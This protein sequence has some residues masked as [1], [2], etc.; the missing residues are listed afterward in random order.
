MNNTANNDILILVDAQLD[1]F[2]Y[3]VDFDGSLDASGNTDDPKYV[4]SNIMNLITQF[5]GQKIIYSQDWHP[6]DHMSF[7]TVQAPDGLTGPYPVHCIQGSRG[8]EIHPAI[9][10]ALNNWQAQNKQ[11]RTLQ[12]VKKACG[13][14]PF[15]VNNRL[16]E[17][18]DHNSVLGNTANKCS[19]DITL[20]NSVDPDDFDGDMLAECIARHCIENKNANIYIAGFVTNICVLSTVLDVAGITQQQVDEIIAKLKYTDQNL[21]V[22]NATKHQRCKANVSINNIFVVANCCLASNYDTALA[23]YRIFEEFAIKSVYCLDDH[24]SDTVVK[25]DLL[26][27]NIN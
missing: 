19:S 8:A 20:G 14:A 18:T 26:E 17:D 2:S 4:L 12:C 6:N 11:K 5:K 23:T 9:M 10:T 3:G 27:T 25:P 13:S 15:V 21:L 1:F 16:K 22:A 7:N 24:L